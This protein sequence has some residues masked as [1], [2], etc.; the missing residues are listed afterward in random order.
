MHITILAMGSRGDVQPSIALA[1]GLKSAGHSVRVG[2]GKNFQEW[3]EAQGLEYGTF[4]VDVEAVMNSSD[5]QNWVEGGDNPLKE[6]ARLRHMF[7][8]YGGPLVKDMDVM[9]RDTDLVMS[10]FVTF[11]AIMCLNEIHHKKHLIVQL[12]P[13]TPTRL[14]ASSMNPIVSGSSVLNLA[15]GY[16]QQFMMWTLFNPMLRRTREQMHLPQYSARSFIR[17]WNA[18]PII[19]GIS[20]LITP[21]A[22]DYPPHVQTAGY[23]FLDE[24]AWTPPEALTKFLE[25]GS[26]PLYLGFGSMSNRNP[27]KTLQTMVNALKQSGQRGV[28]A[29]GWANLS[30]VALPDTVYMLDSAPHSWL[31]PRMAGVIHHGG[32]GTT[33]AGLRAGVPSGIIPHF[34]DQPYWGR[35]VYE[36]GVGAKPVHRSKVSVDNL[37]A[38]MY[39]VATDTRMHDE[40][41]RLGERIRAED[42]IGN[43]A[44]IIGRMAK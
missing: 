8:E 34:S 33:A 24:P 9:L 32:A 13:V 20:P 26:K 3:I 19:H 27:Q 36:L 1:Q 6:L 5:G 37:A 39:A 2:A 17:A 29:S 44:R 38:M 22:P 31:F 23:W 14:G 16:M 21:H 35:R 15:A 12:Q 7:T 18:T 43:A 25:A 11:A 42:G 28:I 10:G 4:N 41:A 30:G 40:A